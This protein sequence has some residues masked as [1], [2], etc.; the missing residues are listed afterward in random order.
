MLKEFELGDLL[1]V[2]TGHLV[3]RKHIAGV[4]EVYSHVLDYPVSTLG[5]VAHHDVVKAEV[6]RQ[7]PD[8]EFV[9]YPEL[10]IKN[11]K[12]IW[13]WLGMMEQE[14]GATLS[15]E[16]LSEKDHDSEGDETTWAELGNKD[17][18]ELG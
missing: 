14:H 11:E 4:Y 3:S 6:L 1:S 12:Q 17:A 13:E 18:Y 9:V 8:L 16:Q 2:T 15:L 10:Q 5:L 7:H